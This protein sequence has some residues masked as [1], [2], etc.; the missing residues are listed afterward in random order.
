MRQATSSK[1]LLPF[2]TISP[3]SP[4]FTLFRSKIFLNLQFCQYYASFSFLSPYKYSVSSMLD[5]DKNTGFKCTTNI[6]RQVK[7]VIFTQ[8]ESCI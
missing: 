1:S 3:A 6:F 2:F 5:F 4:K 7:F 8:I